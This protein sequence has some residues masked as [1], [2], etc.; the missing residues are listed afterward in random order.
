V[1]KRLVQARMRWILRLG[2]FGT[3]LIRGK[4]RGLLRKY[5]KEYDEE[6]LKAALTKIRLG[7]Q[8]SSTGYLLGD[9]L[10]FAGAPVLTHMRIDSLIHCPFA[11]KN[12]PMTRF[13]TYWTQLC[14]G[15]LQNTATVFNSPLRWLVPQLRIAHACETLP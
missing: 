11:S 8:A 7:L 9:S 6:E 13:L 10:S 2:P 5:P 1:F 12:N 14:S 4:L 15:W 3:Y